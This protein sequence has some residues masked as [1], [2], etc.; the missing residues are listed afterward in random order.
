MNGND[1]KEKKEEIEGGLTAFIQVLK[2]L[3]DMSGIVGLLSLTLTAATEQ[4]KKT[5]LEHVKEKRIFY[6]VQVRALLS[7]LSGLWQSTVNKELQGR[8]QVVII[9]WDIPSKNRRREMPLLILQDAY[10]EGKWY[11][12]NFQ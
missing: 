1:W 4:I 5:V 3:Y 8:A 7:T 10:W 2:F 11:L 9:N 12:W 6:L